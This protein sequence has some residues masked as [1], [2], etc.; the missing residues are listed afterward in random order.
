MKHLTRWAV[1]TALI[2]TTLALTA[3]PNQCVDEP[4]SCEAVEMGPNLYSCY[5]DSASS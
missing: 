1:V 5:F 3:Q 2:S 4:Y